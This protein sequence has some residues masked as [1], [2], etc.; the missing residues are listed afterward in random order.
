MKSYIWT[1]VSQSSWV[2]LPHRPDF[3]S[4]FIFTTAQVVFITAII[5]YIFIKQKYVVGYAEIK[6]TYVRFALL[7]TGVRRYS[8]RS[9]LPSHTFLRGYYVTKS[10]H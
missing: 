10:L 5:A 2:R 4:G 7:V 1:A 6:Q 3:F 8:G 9:V